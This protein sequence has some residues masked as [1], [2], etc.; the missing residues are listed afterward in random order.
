MRLNGRDQRT[1][2]DLPAFDSYALSPPLSVQLPP[3]PAVEDTG[4]TSASFRPNC[5]P[6][7]APVSDFANYDHLL[8]GQLRELCIFFL[9]D[10]GLL[11]T[12]PPRSHV[13]PKTRDA[14]IT[15]SASPGGA[16]L[17][18]TVPTSFPV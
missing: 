18:G 10:R 7:Q 1:L 17:I 14:G 6:C 2:K 9:S 4:K 8:Y 11:S 15:P 16:K 5:A 3:E 12:A 13:G